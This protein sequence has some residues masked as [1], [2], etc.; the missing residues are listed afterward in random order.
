MDQPDRQQ[1]QES[2]E[3]H[4]A[5]QHLRRQARQ[6][7]DAAETVALTN[8]FHKTVRAMRLTLALDFRLERDAARDAA[9]AAKAAQ[10]LAN[11]TALRESRI[12]QAAQAAL[13]RMTAPSPVEQQRDR[14]R[15]ALNRLLWNESEGD[16]EEYDVLVEDL[17]ARLD[18][19]EEA[20]GF[21]DL[22]PDLKREPSDILVVKKSGGAFATT[23]LDARLRALGVTQVVLTGV[24]TSNA[25]E[26]TG[27]QAYEQGF[28]VTRTAW[29][30]AGLPYEVAGTT[31]DCQCGSSQQ[32]NH[33][34]NN[35]IACIPGEGCRYTLFNNLFRKRT[36]DGKVEVRDFPAFVAAATPVCVRLLERPDLLTLGFSIGTHRAAAR[37]RFRSDNSA[38]SS[39]S[40]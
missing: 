40:D 8:A 9:E 29:L 14:V 31:I 33:F 18:A 28:N 4:H 3:Q 25:V 36:P 6:S 11:D 26:S 19:A 21:A 23:D 13:G 30:L 39:R 35:L 16:Q 15:G 32:A 22:V 1:R 2:G 24:S 20:E 7:E 10:D 27:R 12:M 17:D 37:M 34:V 5:D 38:V